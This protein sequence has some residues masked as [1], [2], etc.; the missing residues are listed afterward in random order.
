M[1]SSLV[2]LPTMAAIAVML[3]GPAHAQ[4]ATFIKVTV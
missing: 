4:G 3:S 2:V 1:R